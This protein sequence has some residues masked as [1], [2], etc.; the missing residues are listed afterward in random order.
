MHTGTKR[1]ARGGEPKSSVARV[2]VQGAC[3]HTLFSGL[4]PAQRPQPVEGREEDW[5]VARSEF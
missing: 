5:Q 3:H 2:R 4:R 1:S